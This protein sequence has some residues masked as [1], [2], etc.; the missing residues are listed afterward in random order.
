MMKQFFYSIFIIG[1]LMFGKS[2]FALTQKSTFTITH[3][4]PGITEIADDAGNWGG[5]NK[6]TSHQNAENYWTEK[7]IDIPAGALEEIKFARLRTYM[8][9]QDYSFNNHAIKPNGL[10][11]S[12]EVLVNGSTHIYQDNDPTFPSRT[13]PNEPLK[14][15]WHDFAIPISELHEGANTFVFRK[16]HSDKNDDFLYIGIDNTVHNDHSRMSLNGGKTWT[17]K[18]LNAV[19]ASGEYMVRLLLLKETPN[20]IFH[21][22]IGQAIP[23]NQLLGYAGT[24]MQ[25]QRKVLRLEFD[26]EQYDSEKPLNISFQ[27]PVKLPITA[28]D[29]RGK[30]VPFKSTF[31]DNTQNIS[32]A[33]RYQALSLLTVSLLESTFEGLEVRYQ[34]P[35]GNLVNSTEAA[36]NMAPPVSSPAGKMLPRKPQVRLT[37]NGFILENGDMVADFQSKPNLR[38]DSLRNEY[39]QKNVLA[40]PEQ[41]HLFLI[42]KEGKRYGAEDWNVTDVK[43]LSPQ[44]I[45]VNLDLPAQQLSAIW[46]VSIDTQGLHFALNITNTAPKTQSWKTAFPQIGGLQL[47]G[48]SNDDY[49]LLPYHEGLIANKNTSVS[50]VYG[51]RDAWWQ[52]V[53]LFSPK[54]GAGLL[55]RNLDETGLLKDI[56]FQ[57]GNTDIAIPKLFNRAADY[58]TD[59]ATV[60]DTVLPTAPGAAIAF[61][62]TT[63]E[64]EAGKSF[65][66]PDALLQMHTGDWHS[67]MRIY[68]DWAHRVW[69]WRPPNN[70]L[71]DVWQIS[72]LG[73]TDNPIQPAMIDKTGWRADHF[74]GQVQAAELMTWWEWSDKGPWK[75]PLD[76]A[77]EKLGEAFYNRFKYMFSA[78]DPVT[79]KKGY[80]FNRGD[81]DYNQSWGGKEGVQ[82]Y[83]ELLHQNKQLA[84]L[85]TD[86]LLVDDNTRLAKDAPDYAIMNPL[87]KDGYKVPLD[88]PG[89]VV[90][91]ASYRMC[92]DNE[93]YQNFVVQQMTRI[94]KDTNVD[95][96]RLDEFGYGNIATCFNPKHKHLFA[97]SG[98]NATFQAEA[99]MSKSIHEAVDKIHPGF[100]LMTEDTG[101]DHL[102]ANVEGALNYTLVV[103]NDPEMRP[104]PLS[105]FR[106]YFPEHKLYMF[107]NGRDLKADDFALWNGI[108]TFEIFYPPAYAKILE[109]NGDAFSDPDAKPLISTLAPRV[110]ANQF[111]AGQKTITTLYNAR[112]FTVDRPLLKV[113]SDKNYHYFDLLNCRE[114]DVKDNAISLYLHPGDVAAVAKLPKVLS[115][116]DHVVKLSRIPQNAV[117]TLCDINGNELWRQSVKNNS[118][119]LPASLPEGAVA[120]KLFAGKYLTDVTALSDSVSS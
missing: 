6:G 3:P 9:S 60:W 25:D 84:V 76:Q 103:N 7:T 23:D 118:I 112:K 12:F 15:D 11:E 97:E 41:T 40:H 5:I 62:Y 113:L 79:G 92:L 98:H 14:W 37:A 85:Y 63:Y 106:F 108:G 30:A 19:K 93:R 51:G 53:D 33:P 73:W 101:Y 31:V 55:L 16:T 10:D 80:M 67:A 70:K 13:N 110:Y 61:S 107:N 59:P 38:L 45:Q 52:M 17:T 57:K 66:P 56:D 71:R 102:A 114:L 83:V 117:I 87:W 105:V 96:I 21:W 18:E 82:K 47:S 109:E 69:Q 58:W 50:T 88:P 65:A 75:V 74:K 94:V 119:T 2:T 90:P 48:E 77:K 120:V 89:Y 35:V 64:R 68:A 100:I 116:Q 27:T 4:Q 29:A 34:K 46:S 1:M 8:F 44:K 111:Q 32:I 86:P 24:E 22:K 26:T 49:Y 54:S 43:V 115:V 95:G 20:A 104:V 99:L 72:S 39:L 91:Y 78:V 42:E 81:Y 28:L 36:I